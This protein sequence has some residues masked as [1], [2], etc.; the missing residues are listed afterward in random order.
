MSQEK[1][2]TRDLAFWKIVFSLGLAS[3]FIFGTMYSMQP[4]LPLLTKNY[5]ISISYASLAMS[6]TTV[7]LIFGLLILGFLT[8]RR[9]RTIFIH[10]SIATTT[11]LLFII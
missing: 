4:L 10:V 8:D 3:F 6:L 5:D 2:T 7:G 11:I 9:G 1:Y